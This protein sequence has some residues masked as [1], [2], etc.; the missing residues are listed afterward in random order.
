MAVIKTPD[1]RILPDRIRTIGLYRSIGGNEHY[2]T[3]YY[4][5][6][7][8]SSITMPGIDKA[9]Q[10]IGLQAIGLVRLVMSIPISKDSGIE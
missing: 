8:E 5:N 10:S 2:G 1:I 6:I 9:E 7:C 4:H 3:L